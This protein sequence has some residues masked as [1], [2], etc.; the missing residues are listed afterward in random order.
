VSKRALKRKVVDKLSWRDHEIKVVHASD[1]V[2]RREAVLSVRYIL[3]ERRARLIEAIHGAQ[4][5]ALELAYAVGCPD[6]RTYSGHFLH[7]VLPQPIDSAQGRGGN[8]GG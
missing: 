1:I 8:D 7:V 2:I 3:I 4:V 6:K 5:E